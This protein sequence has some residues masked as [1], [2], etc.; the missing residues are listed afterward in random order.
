MHPLPAL[1]ARGVKAALSNDDPALMGQDSAG[2]A[3]DFWQALQGWGSLGLEGLVS[4]FPL[5]LVGL[6]GCVV[7]GCLLMLCLQG[8]LAQNS[9]RWSAFEDQSDEEWHEDVSKGADGT[10]LRAQRIRE[11]DAEWEVFCGWIVKEFG[12]VE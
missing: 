2:L 7:L 3:H 5:V 1:L 6:K 11:W 12:D 8:S 9:V 4:Y 10:G